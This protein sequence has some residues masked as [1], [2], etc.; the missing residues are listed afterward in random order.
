MFTSNSYESD[1]VKVK[2]N[3]GMQTKE[4]LLTK[5]AQ[6]DN[7]IACLYQSAE[8][9]ALTADVIEYEIDT[10][11]SKMKT[12]FN[13]PDQV[14]ASIERYEKLRQMLQNRLISP[15]TQLMDSKNFYGNGNIRF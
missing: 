6:L 5:I 9:L 8:Q 10:G 4:Q 2:L 12:K 15:R 11:Q 14:T 3:S 7:I 13:S 1:I